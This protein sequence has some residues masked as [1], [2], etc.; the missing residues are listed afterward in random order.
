MHELHVLINLLSKLTSHYYYMKVPEG[1]H[2]T[3]RRRETKSS[4]IYLKATSEDKIGQKTDDMTYC[5]IKMFDV[6]LYPSDMI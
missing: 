1:V 2:R 6:F 4:T 3:F 5:N